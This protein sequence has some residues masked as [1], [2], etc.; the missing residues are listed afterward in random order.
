M[1]LEE[2]W[3]LFPIVLVEHNPHWKVWYS[4]EEHLL[5]RLIPQ[6]LRISHIGS[7]AIE[8]IWAKPIIDILVELP[9]SCSLSAI[10]AELECNG[11]IIMNESASRISLNKGYTLDGF[12]EKVFHLHLRFI[13]DNDELYFRKYLEEN[14]VIANEYETLK[15]DLWQK[16]EFDRDTY[17]DA[18]AEFVAKYTNIAKLAYAD[19]VDRPCSSR[20]KDAGR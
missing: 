19:N 5:R 10:A 4:E 16:Y 9:E 3:Q 12:A 14:Q 8:G 6:A 2:L 20:Y 7:T 17:T 13:G 15:L 18:K 1:S 11:Y